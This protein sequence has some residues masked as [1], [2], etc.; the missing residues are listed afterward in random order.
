VLIFSKR[1][2]NRIALARVP[3][4]TTIDEDLLLKMKKK[5]LDY[6]NQLE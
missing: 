5:A 2:I 3:F 1:F 6:K 4:N